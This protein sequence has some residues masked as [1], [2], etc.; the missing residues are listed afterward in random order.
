MVKVGHAGIA[1]SLR[2][3]FFEHGINGAGCA[4]ARR[5][6]ILLRSCRLGVRTNQA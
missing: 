2:R 3:E 4:R 1:N 5:R 6:V